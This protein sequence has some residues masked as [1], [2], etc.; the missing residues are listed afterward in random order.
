MNDDETT[1]KKRR[2]LAWWVWFTAATGLSGVA[3]VALLSGLVLIV[4]G[5]VLGGMFLWGFF[6][7]APPS[8]HS[9]SGPPA[10]E[11]S[12]RN[13]TITSP[14]DSPSTSPS[15]SVSHHAKPRKPIGSVPIS[16]SGTLA[17]NGSTGPASG[18]DTST[19]S[20]NTSGALA[21]G[22]SEALNVAILNPNSAAATLSN[23]ILSITA[24]SAPNA[25]STL[26]CTVND[27]F[28]T[29]AAPG[30]SITLAPAATTWLSDS[31]AAPTGWPRVGM[32]DTTLNQNGCKSA[33]VFYAYTATE[34]SP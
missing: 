27:Y 5:A 4:A 26:T 14:S 8:H 10:P 18:T 31:G 34:V 1:R 30:F 32:T 20:G 29:Q 28:I 11:R 13:D 23:L 33:T 25:T 22:N 9:S 16:G 21:P 12:G 17:T 24:V 15:P 19:T 7:S 6:D 3:G 2:K